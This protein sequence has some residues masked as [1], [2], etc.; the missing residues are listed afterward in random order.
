MS[1]ERTNVVG[2]V[3][4]T[5]VITAG[6]LVAGW[7]AATRYLNQPAAPVAHEEAPAAPTPRRKTPRP[8]KTDNARG[9]HPESGSAKDASAGGA[10]AEQTDA[11]RDES[12]AASSS[13]R[14]AAAPQPDAEP[15]KVRTDAELPSVAIEPVA[16][17]AASENSGDARTIM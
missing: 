6:V 14:G 16:A 9:E 13:G 7:F 12:E 17:A 8:A 4:L 10:A 15:V 2:V 11:S 3:I 5:T 1:R